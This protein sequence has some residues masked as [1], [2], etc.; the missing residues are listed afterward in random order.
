M[1]STE[2]GS[3]IDESFGKLKLHFRRD[4]FLVRETNVVQKTLNRF[5]EYTFRRRGS[6]LAHA[7]LNS[8]LRFENRGD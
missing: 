6:G 1:Q 3:K 4:E 8:K 2:S 5:W 7:E